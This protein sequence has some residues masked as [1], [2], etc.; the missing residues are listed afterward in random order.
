RPAGV[1]V[2]V[3]QDR[4]AGADLLHAAAAG[5]RA[6]ERVGVGTVERERAVV[7]HIAEDRT[8]GPA[9]NKLPRAARNGGAAGVGVGAPQDQRAGRG[10][11]EPAAA[12][13][14]AGEIT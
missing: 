5:D 3:R 10:L 4:G 12:G 2:S 1:G 13:E 11:A 7:S 9:V 6:A 14:R 8:S